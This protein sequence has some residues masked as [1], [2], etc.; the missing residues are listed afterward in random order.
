MTPHLDLNP[1]P[2]NYASVTITSETKCHRSYPFGLG[3]DT[4]K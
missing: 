1:P 4:V 2:N 3:L